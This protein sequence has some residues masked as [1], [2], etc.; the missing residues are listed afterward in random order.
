MCVRP[1]GAACEYTIAAASI[2]CRGLS[3]FQCLHAA[4]LLMTK[5]YRPHWVFTSLGGLL[6]AQPLPYLIITTLFL[7]VSS[8]SS[9]QAS[10]LGRR[11]ASIAHGPEIVPNGA[12][13][14]VPMNTHPKPAS[15]TCTF[16]KVPL[17]TL[18]GRLPAPGCWRRS[19][20]AAPDHG[21]PQ[22]LRQPRS[23]RSAQHSAPPGRHRAE[24]VPTLHQWHR[25]L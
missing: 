14:N 18:G 10:S 5:H 9:L 8:I 2:P 21:G 15:G 25:I 12:N 24:T 20:C 3:G 17:M 23:G 22:S 7:I 16:D 13:K 19:C 4:V 6:S 1:S 11:A